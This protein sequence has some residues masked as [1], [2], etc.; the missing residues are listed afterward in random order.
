MTATEV[1][2]RVDE[3]WERDIVP[4][5]REYIAIPNVSQV[6][7]PKWAELGHMERAVDL[8]R[9][10]AGTR[11]I[12]GMTVEVH[13][14]EGRSPVLFMEIPPANGGPVDDTVL[15]YGHLDKQP[16]MTGWR[17]GLSPWEPVL[18][19]DL[20]YGRGGADDGYA[21]FA[22]LTAV[23]MAQE[24]GSPHARC[25]VL[26]ESSEESG[27]RDLPAHVDA[28]ADRIGTP[29]LVV[30]L[31]SGCLDYDHLW[32]TTSLRGLLAGQLDVSIS[33]EGVH[34]GD[35][36]GVIPSTFR[37]ARELLS[38]L[39]DEGTGAIH[40]PEAQVAV[41]DDRLE[42]ARATAASMNAPVAAK[43]PFLDG[44]RPVTDDPV[45]QLLNRAWRPWLEITG[46]DGL[47]PCARAGNVLRPSTS[48]YLSLRIPPTADP[49]AANDALTGLLTSNPPFG[50]TVSYRADKTSTGWNAPP[51]ASWL[52]ESLDQASKVAFGQPARTVGE[53]GSISFMGMLGSQ[54]PDAQF[55]V[56]GVLGPG[57]NA[58]GPNESL[59][60]PTAKR[61][62]EVIAAVL[63]DHANR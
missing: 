18:D 33:S 51:F 21:T 61:L 63:R 62:T 3:V 25:V 57:S 40:L 19:G 20:L 37:I 2:Q 31:D 32:V 24:A 16:E 42:Q 35:A 60:I 6:F 11:P 52:E 53:G 7:E 29:S 38:R 59:H 23:Q 56:T 4:T 5:L 9:D 43:F 12:G 15:L 26:I 45:E 27:S 1:T 44:A 55:V 54:F 48:L 14:I 41:P 28:L 50:A 46:A 34:S 36:S 49:K 10:W 39:E 47:P 13:R 30:C 58:H 8:L 17:D 22:A